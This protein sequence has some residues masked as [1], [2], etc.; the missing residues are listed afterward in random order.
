MKTR[1]RVYSALCAVLLALGLSAT[2]LGYSDVAQETWYYE[3][4][5]AVTEQGLMQGVTSER[6]AP[7]GYVTRATVITTLWRL[8]G[9]PDVTVSSVF[10]DVPGKHW[11]YTAAAWA[12]GAGIATGYSDGVFGPEDHVTREQL[13]VFL[14]RYA[15]YKGEPIAEGVVTLY[16]DAQFIHAWALGGVKHALGTGL[17]TGTSSGLSPLGLATRAELAAILVRLTTPVHG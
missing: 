14:Y 3:T 9:S 15:I 1:Q 13:A 16:A 2:T 7:E 11:A 6:F 12:K 8:E 4:I 10:P 5:Q 17:M